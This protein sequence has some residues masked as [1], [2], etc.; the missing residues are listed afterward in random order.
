ML[1]YNTIINF[2]QL[3]EAQIKRNDHSSVND[4]FKY[5]LF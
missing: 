2:V 1:D 4:N 3:D 5:A